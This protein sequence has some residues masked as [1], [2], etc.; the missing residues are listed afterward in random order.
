M[1]GVEQG[2]DRGIHRRRVVSP[3]HVFADRAQLSSGLIVC[4]PRRRVLGAALE[5][6]P[7]ARLLALTFHRALEAFAIE[8]QLAIVDHVLD[9]I[10]R[11]SERVIEPERDVT[12]DDLVGGSRTVEDLFETWQAA[13]ADTQQTRLDEIRTT[14][15]KYPMIPAL[16]AAIAHYGGDTA[17]AKVRPPLVELTPEQNRGLIAD[18]D[19]RGFTMPG[20]RV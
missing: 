2:N 19:A 13:D 12:G 20:L 6:A 9:E 10:A 11:Q 5:R 7:G 18:L 16:K 1:I 17:W 15:A 3:E 4:R 14:F 8:R